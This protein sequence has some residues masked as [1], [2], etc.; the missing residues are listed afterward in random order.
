MAQ[1]VSV[2]IP[3]PGDSIVDFA[4]ALV[5]DAKENGESMGF[6]NGIKLVVS[7]DDTITSVVEDYYKQVRR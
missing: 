1:K 6:F 2:W 7:S 4:Q 3:T 5:L